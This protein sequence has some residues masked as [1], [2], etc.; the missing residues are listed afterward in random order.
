MAEICQRGF[1][2]SQSYT[3]SWIVRARIPIADGL[4]LKLSSEST[5]ALA[6]ALKAIHALHAMNKVPPHLL[7]HL[8]SLVWDWM[9][10]IILCRSC[11]PHPSPR[12][13]AL[14]Y[15]F[16]KVTSYINAGGFFGDSFTR[17]IRR[18]PK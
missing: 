8:W 16:A 5:V 10:L 17:P 1:H 2:F 3:L 6:Q 9:Q 14:Y 4:D 15:E 18:S 7:I 13:E 11:L 12:D